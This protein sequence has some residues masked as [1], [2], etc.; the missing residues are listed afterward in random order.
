M[1]GKKPSEM[2]HIESALK[3]GEAALAALE[4]MVEVLEAA[5]SHGQWDLLTPGFAPKLLKHERLDEAEELAEDAHEDLADFGRAL[6]RLDP[7]SDF[8]S[9]FEIDR[10][11][12]L[13]DFLWNGPL[14][15]WLA[16]R[17][18]VDSLDRVNRIA[19]DL[20]KVLDGLSEHRRALRR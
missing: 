17:G 4:R 13:N 15:T 7:A 10:L 8:A 14:T 9:R 3:I 11:S 16:Q 2:A 19:N 12:R 18:I 1:T 6:R 20:S 5:R